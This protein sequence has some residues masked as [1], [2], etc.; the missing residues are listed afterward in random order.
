MIRFFLLIRGLNARI[1]WSVPPISACWRSLNWRTANSLLVK[2]TAT[3]EEV[4]N[5]CR[6][7]K[8]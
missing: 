6:N 8:E 2:L 4:V 7:S 3:L 5:F 1:N